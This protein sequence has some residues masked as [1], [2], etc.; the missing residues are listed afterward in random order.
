MVMSFN[1]SF[2][3]ANTREMDMGPHH[4]Y[5]TTKE[6]S[7]KNVDQVYAFIIN[8]SVNLLICKDSQTLSCYKMSTL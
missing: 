7:S 2:S 3:L 1:R 6:A 4:K 5:E 8:K